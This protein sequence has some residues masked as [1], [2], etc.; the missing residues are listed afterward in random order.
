MNVLFG[1]IIERKKLLP[2]T[3]TR[4]SSQ[5]RCGILTIE[6]KWQF[7]LKGTFSHATAPYLSKLFPSEVAE[8]NLLIN[9]TVLPTPA[10]ATQLENLKF[11]E[12]L[13]SDQH[14]IAARLSHEGLVRYQSTGIPLGNEVKVS[15]AC[16]RLE[17][18]WHIFQL[19]GQEIR[20]DFKLLT[21]G[22]K[23]AEAHPTATI[24]GDHV[25]IEEGAD[26]VNCSLNSLNGPIYIGKG[27]KVEDGVLIKGPFA[28]CE[29]AVANMGAK[30]RSDTTVG[31]YCKVGGE[32]SN[33]VL[34]G[35][36]NKGHD[37]FLGNSVIGEW[38]N[39]GADTNCSNLK[40]DYGPV[41]VWD[42]DS[43]SSVSTESQFCGLVMGDHS[44]CGINTMF[45]TGTVVGVSANIF[46]GDF[47]PKFIP[48]FSWGGSAGFTEYRFEKAIQVAKR[49]MIRRKKELSEN[50]L[51]LLETVFNE[52]KKFRNQ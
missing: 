14:W 38:C 42:Y 44:K 18:T 20:T 37:G 12:V 52:T 15:E 45:N 17:H 11:G 4:P 7:Y 16:E 24:I 33:S 49:V 26:V 6:E 23:S 13:I 48:S 29:A 25:F 35:Y 1:D 31:P 21:L 30:L 32:I 51:A 40:N 9:G 10:L 8:D 47:P 39:L 43:E 36:S 3:F 19:N 5:I 27:A 41:S 34:Q 22:R 28:L 50:D 46:G 2:L